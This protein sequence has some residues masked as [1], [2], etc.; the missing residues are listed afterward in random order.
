MKN[1]TRNILMIIICVIAAICLAIVD[2]STYGVITKGF[3][4]MTILLLGSIIIPSI[5]E[6]IK[7]R[8]NKDY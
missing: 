1:R 7:E 6:L 4:G 3:L 5:M 8:K 2:I